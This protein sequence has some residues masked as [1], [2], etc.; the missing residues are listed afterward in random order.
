MQRTTLPL[1]LKVCFYTLSYLRNYVLHIS[2]Q[3][4]DVCFV[5]FECFCHTSA[6]QEGFLF[7]L[8][9]VFLV[10]KWHVLSKQLWRLRTKRQ[11]GCFK[12][13]VQDLM[14]KSDE[15]WFKD[16]VLFYG[17]DCSAAVAVQSSKD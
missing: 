1:P 6:D 8:F 14:N 12:V 10:C 9:L 5:S 13:F 11:T 7:G 3:M 16:Y 17:N 2:L 4:Q 15:F